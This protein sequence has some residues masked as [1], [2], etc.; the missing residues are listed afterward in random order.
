M[1]YGAAG[2]TGTNPIGG[3]VGYASDYRQSDAHCIIESLS[4]LNLAL[5]SYGRGKLVWIPDGITIT[6]P[7]VYSL[8]NRRILRDNIRCILAADRSSGT[9]AR[10]EI[11]AR[12]KGY[13]PRIWP[14]S[15]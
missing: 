3:G 2:Y 15:Y 13:L 1:P 8:S 14:S 9:G 4:D 5:V 12:A 10:I 7:S 6:I 11:P